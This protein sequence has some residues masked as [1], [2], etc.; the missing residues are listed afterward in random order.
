[1]VDVL[2]NPDSDGLR[3]DNAS[4]P[5]ER[6]NRAPHRRGRMNVSHM[7]SQTDPGLAVNYGADHNGPGTRAVNTRDQQFLLPPVLRRTDGARNN[8]VTF[9]GSSPSPPQSTHAPS[10]P[11][12]SK[13]PNRPTGLAEMTYS[14][15][16]DL[17]R[18]SFPFQQDTTSV[19]PPVTN[20]IGA[21]DPR[22]QGGVQMPPPPQPLMALPDAFDDSSQIFSQFD[23]GWE[24]LFASQA[25]T[26]NFQNFLA[27]TTEDLSP[28]G[29]IPGHA[30]TIPAR[31]VE[32][33]TR[34]GDNFA[35]VAPWSAMSATWRS[36]NFQHEE[37]F[38]NIELTGNT[39]ERMLAIAQTFFRLA[40]DSLNV[41]SNPG[42]RFLMADM[43]KYSSSSILML[44][45][46][47]VL[48]T[49][50]ETFLTSFEPFYPLV[51]L[52]TLDPNT[53][54]ADKQEHLAMVLILL[55]IAYGAMRDSAIK[56]RRLSM[57]LLEI[58]RLTLLHFLDKDST[59]PRSAIA[60]HCALLSTYQSAFSGDKWLMNSSLGQM[61]QYLIVSKTWTWL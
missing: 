42:M 25:A 53:I 10:T 45:P 28:A 1:M 26:P 21:P 37:R 8:L 24:G 22:T 17:T 52:R 6:P 7:L 14:I 33:V 2:P 13:E 56:A 18:N 20:G 44:P 57:G 3:E 41:S 40:L 32:N 38:E 23:W 27:S 51:E 35:D 34:L 46:T 9:A 15:P 29:S 61:H 43:K 49:Y 58:C 4:D 54:A 19:L 31:S 16:E 11:G 55:M 48:H 36:R 59:N 50:L 60:T 30:V 5:A 12:L 39:R 47:P